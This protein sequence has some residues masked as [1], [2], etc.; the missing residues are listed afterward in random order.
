MPGAIG[1][2]SRLDYNN[3]FNSGVTVTPSVFWADDVDGVSMDPTF[4]EGRQTLG[5]GLQV[6]LQ[7]ELQPRDE[8]RRLCGR[9]FR[10]AV[11]SRLLL[12][13]RQRDLLIRCRSNDTMRT[14]NSM[15]AAAVALAGL[16]LPAQAKHHRRGGRASRR[17]ADADRS[18]ESGQRGRDDSG[19]DAAGSPAHRRAGRPRRATSIRSPRDKVKFTITGANAD[20][21][22]DKLTP[23][24]L[25]MLQ[26]VRRPSR[27][28]CTRRGARRPIRR[29]STTR[30]SRRRRR[31]SC[32][33]LRST[34][35]GPPPCRSRSRRTASR[36][37]G[38]TRALPRRRHRSVRTFLPGPRERRLLQDRRPRIPHLQRQPRSA[39][40]QPAA[41]S[42]RVFHRA[43][44]ARGH[45]VPGARAGR[46]G[47]AAASAWIYNAG[48]APRAPRAGPRLRQHQ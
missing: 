46:P 4:I 47:E 22:K 24:T 36:R 13:Q 42:C 38:T 27:C 39:A 6:Q 18:G 8:L 43:G 29:P 12:G 34:I 31:W 10:S 26:E 44:D 37:S 1:C 11:R 25:A 23:G 30:S 33:V 21:Y 19:L 17:R 7:Q 32:R 35:W 2:G 15:I 41:R 28:R 45:G 14:I 20:Q 16:A 40:G 3:V 48:P 9:R 5:L